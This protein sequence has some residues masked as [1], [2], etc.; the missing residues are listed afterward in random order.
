MTF[1]CIFLRDLCVNLVF[2]LKIKMKKFKM[3]FPYLMVF[4]FSKGKSTVQT[5]KKIFP[6]YGNSVIAESTDHKWCTK[7]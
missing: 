2:T 5:A 7:F 4:Y 3:H 6:I 1:Q